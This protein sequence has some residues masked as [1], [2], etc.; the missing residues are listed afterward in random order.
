M[1]DVLLNKT[2]LNPVR[3]VVAPVCGTR[4]S[5]KEIT[6]LVMPSATAKA[7]QHGKTT[8]S[9]CHTNGVQTTRFF[10][11]HMCFMC[12]FLIYPVCARADVSDG[13]L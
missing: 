11:T 1:F 6:T 12:R 9:N 7:N 13:G 10:Q 3:A 8:I 4:T 5:S 2:L